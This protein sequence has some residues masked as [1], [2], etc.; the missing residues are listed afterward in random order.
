MLYRKRVV[1]LKWK[2]SIIFFRPS[3]KGIILS[4]IAYEVSYYVDVSTTLA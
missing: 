2:F 1:I 4:R 3:L